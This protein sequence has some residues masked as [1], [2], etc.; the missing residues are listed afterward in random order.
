MIMMMKKTIRRIIAIGVLVAAGAAFVTP[1]NAPAG[2]SRLRVMTYNIYRGGT[3]HKQ[4]LSQT[5]KV[6]QATDWGCPDPGRW[7]GL[8]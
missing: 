4:P 1:Q 6:I 8:L 5:V 7:P 3:M 2:E